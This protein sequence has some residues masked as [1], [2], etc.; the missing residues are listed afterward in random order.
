MKKLEKLKMKQVNA[1][2]I[3]GGLFALVSE[4]SV[5]DSQTMTEHHSPCWNGTKGD[6]QCD[7]TYT[8]DK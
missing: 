2:E 3:K 7:H 5:S 8:K 1:S 6:Y 4:L